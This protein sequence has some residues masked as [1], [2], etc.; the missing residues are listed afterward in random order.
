MEVKPNIDIKPDIGRVKA[1]EGSVKRE[2]EDAPYAPSKSFRAAVEQL[3]QSRQT[4]SELGT[5]GASGSSSR[6]PEGHSVKREVKSEDEPRAPSETFIA[7]FRN[8]RGQQQ[9]QPPPQG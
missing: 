2:L 5:P 4:S 8:V 6:G 7:A 9:A 3:Q 1:E